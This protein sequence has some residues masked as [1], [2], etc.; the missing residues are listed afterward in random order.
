M[1]SYSHTL[2]NVSDILVLNKSLEGVTLSALTE[3]PNIH[4]I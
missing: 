2:L 3:P 1:K 4:Q